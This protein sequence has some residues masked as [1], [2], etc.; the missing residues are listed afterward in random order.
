MLTKTSKRNTAVAILCII[1]MLVSVVVV[2]TP[3]SAASKAHLRKTNVSIYLKNVYYQKLYTSSGKQIS[4]SKIKWT[5]NNASVATVNSTGKITTHKIGTARIS[6]KYGG[7]YYRSYITVKGKIVG[8]AC[9]ID[10]AYE[11]AKYPPSVELYRVYYLPKQVDYYGRV[12]DKWI[13]I[14][15]AQNSYGGYGKL[16]VVAQ[17]RNKSTGWYDKAYNL[18]INGKKYYV[19]CRAFDADPEISYSQYSR[20]KNTE[21]M[22]KYKS[23]FE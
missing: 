8:A 2:A 4:N 13:C 11:V 1:M 20:L 22:K 12:F 23:L 3:A 18:K 19:E 6:A 17:K 15:H 7:K 10:T 9:A 14:F 21:C 16:Y 5:T